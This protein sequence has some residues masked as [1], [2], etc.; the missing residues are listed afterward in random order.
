[1]MYNNT[2]VDVRVKFHE[3]L[4]DT[5]LAIDMWSEDYYKLLE[6]IGDDDDYS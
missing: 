3:C 5:N 2:K 6:L 4:F 1:M